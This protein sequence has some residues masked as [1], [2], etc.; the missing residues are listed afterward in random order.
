MSQEPWYMARRS[1][2]ALMTRMQ[3]PYGDYM[4]CNIYIVFIS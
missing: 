2:F 3:D 4:Q 1:R